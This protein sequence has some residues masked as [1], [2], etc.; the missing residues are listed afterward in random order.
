MSTDTILNTQLQDFIG[1]FNVVL[2]VDGIFYQLPFIKLS[3][4]PLVRTQVDLEA[5][6]GCFGNRD[7]EILKDLKASFSANLPYFKARYLTNVIEP[8]KRNYK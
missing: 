7:E 5:L 8:S 6:W 3:N 2:Q 4:D 1:R